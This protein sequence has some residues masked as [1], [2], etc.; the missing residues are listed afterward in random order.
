M[1]L[2]DVQTI[3]SMTYICLFFFCHP[4]HNMRNLMNILPVDATMLYPHFFC[5]VDWDYLLFFTPVSYIGVH[6]CNAT[7]DTLYLCVDYWEKSVMP[8]CPYPG[9]P[10]ILLCG[11]P[12]EPMLLLSLLIY[13]STHALCCFTCC[14]VRHPF[15]STIIN[16]YITQIWVYQ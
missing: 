4:S 3:L 9:F 2:Q 7:L 6:N 11:S 15:N 16:T 10:G 8:I 13:D 14:L 1:T 5:T 12:F